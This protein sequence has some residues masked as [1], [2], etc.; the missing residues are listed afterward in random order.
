M[1]RV[2]VDKGVVG[3]QRIDKPRALLLL[4]WAEAL[5]AKAGKGPLQGRVQ[6][7]LIAHTDAPAGSL[8]Q[9][10]MKQQYLFF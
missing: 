2:P 10:L 3:N 8:S 4:G 6:Q 9:Q 7:A 5:I 1:L